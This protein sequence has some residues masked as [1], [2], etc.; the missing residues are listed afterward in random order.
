M[1]RSARKRANAN[2]R[3]VGKWANRADIAP[4]VAAGYDRNGAFTGDSARLFA[5]GFDFIGA[6]NWPF[7]A[8]LLNVAAWRVA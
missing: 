2:A 6:V 5:T 1:T 7:A 8:E 3:K 4:I